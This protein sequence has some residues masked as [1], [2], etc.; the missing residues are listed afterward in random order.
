MYIMYPSSLP[1]K[2]SGRTMACSITMQSNSF[3]SFINNFICLIVCP[4]HLPVSKST[5]TGAHFNF[6]LLII[7]QKHKER[8]NY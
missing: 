1:L 6:P 5:N 3:R 2:L 7:Q 4:E 8:L